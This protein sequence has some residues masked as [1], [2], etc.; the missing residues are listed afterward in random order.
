MAGQCACRGVIRSLHTHLILTTE[1]LRTSSCQDSRG[2]RVSPE[3][4]N[5]L[6]RM[7]TWTARGPCAKI[8]P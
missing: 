6:P 8:E 1:G 7:D 2:T 4:R 3:A 5:L